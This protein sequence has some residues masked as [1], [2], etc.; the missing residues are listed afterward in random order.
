MNWA[1]RM[2]FDVVGPTFSPS[3][4]DHDGAPDDDTRSCPTDAGPSSYYDGPPY[5]YVSRLANRFHDI[6][7]DAEQSLWRGY[8]K[9]QLGV[10]AELVDI[11]IDGHISKRIYD[12]ISQ[13]ADHILPR[14]HP[15][16]Y[17]NTM[18]L[19]MEKIDACK[20]GR[21]LYWKDDIH[22]NY[23][24]FYGEARYKP[25]RE[26]N[27]NCKKTPYAILRYLP[28]TLRL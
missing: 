2:I 16:D 13:W 9:S 26:R 25:I 28:L 23:Y 21:M 18:C 6:V 3:N 19:P 14:D 7:H 8:T 15:C 10:V 22:L 5:D 27:P 20:N 17:Y 12:R 4:Y 24:K 11:K 1:Q